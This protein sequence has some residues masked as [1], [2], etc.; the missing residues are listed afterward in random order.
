M[1]KILEVTL[2]RKHNAKGFVANEIRQ[3][4]LI[5]LVRVGR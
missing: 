1:V 5:G 4:Q 2:S 3:K